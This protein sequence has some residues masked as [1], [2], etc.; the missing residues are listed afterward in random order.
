MGFWAITKIEILFVY[1]LRECRKTFVVNYG[2]RNSN[3]EPIIFM[4]LGASNYIISH[5][6]I[7]WNFLLIKFLIQI[8]FR[9]FKYS[10]QLL[11]IDFSFELEAVPIK[12]AINLCSK[13]SSYNLVLDKKRS[14]AAGK[15]SVAEGGSKSVTKTYSG[16]IAAV[17]KKFKR[18]RTETFALY[19]Y[20]V[21]KQVHPEKGI[22]RKAMSIVNS[23][24]KC[25]F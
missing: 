7:C 15:K 1:F 22:S 19:I 25:F 21:L 3:P 9:G 16:G 18:K 11:K 17:N 10:I 23:M 13:G 14:M 5:R 8:K 6:S 24:V 4:R 12:L 20:K 2:L